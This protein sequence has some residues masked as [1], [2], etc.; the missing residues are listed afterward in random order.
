MIQGRNCKHYLGSEVFL[1]ET[2]NVSLCSFHLLGYS[3]T[4]AQVISNMYAKSQL[5]FLAT[6]DGITVN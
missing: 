2:I 1:W 6:I 4:F 3:M 5:L